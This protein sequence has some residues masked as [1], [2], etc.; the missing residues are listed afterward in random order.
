MKVPAYPWKKG[1]HPEY[2]CLSLEVE[3]CKDVN[4]RIY[5]SHKLASPEDEAL[6]VG[7]NGAVSEAANALFTEA[8][9]RESIYQFLL[10]MSKDPNFL[11]TLQNASEEQRETLLKEMGTNLETF[12]TKTTRDISLLCMKE[13]YKTLTENSR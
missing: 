3:I 9:R 8:F 13:A 2:T 4:G 7:W 12:V 6:A 11:S 10:Q 5:S 1:V